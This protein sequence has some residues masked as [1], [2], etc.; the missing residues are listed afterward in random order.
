[1]GVLSLEDATMYLGRNLSFHDYHE[2]ELKHRLK[3]AWAKFYSLH[4]ELCSTSYSLKNR[5]RLFE[6]VVT[7]TVLYSAG[8]W[9]MLASREQAL[10]KTQ[11]SMLRKMTRVGRRTVEQDSSSSS[12]ASGVPDTDGESEEAELEEETL[13]PF[14][15][16]LKRA[17][18]ISE[19]L[20]HK[21][22]LQDWVDAQRSRKWRLAGHIARRTDGRWSTKLLSWSP[23]GHRSQGHPMTRWRDELVSFTWSVYGRGADWREIAQDRATWIALE[24][25]FVNKC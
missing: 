2:I 15:D 20:A 13:E 18:H 4:D 16:W 19:E 1:M 7:P 24:E 5:L 12:G 6:S 14:I 9:T 10:R 11:R 23:S 21:H 17:T 25:G 3:R 8:T 22:G